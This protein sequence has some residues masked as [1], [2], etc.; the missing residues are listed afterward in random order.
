MGRSKSS[1]QANQA[2]TTTS[3]DSRVLNES[4]IVAQGSSLDLSSYLDTSVRNTTTNNTTDNSSMNFSDSSNRSVNTSWSDYSNRSTNLADSRSWSDSSSWT[5]SSNNSTNLADS[6]SWTT[7]SNDAS[8]SGSYNTTTTADPLIAKAAFDFAAGSDARNGEGFDK[9]LDFAKELTNGAQ[10]SA[11]SMSARFQ[12]NVLQ[13]FDGA[14]NTTPGGI[15]NKT[16]IVLGL[17]V[18]GAVAVA[19]MARKG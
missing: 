4:G 7:N 17:G 10:E 1:S 18:A 6:R 9:L 12:D 11:S 3:S 5:D 14:R 2:Q 13:A 15:D 16:L 8:V 19:A